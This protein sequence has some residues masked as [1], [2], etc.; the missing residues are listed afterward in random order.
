MQGLRFGRNL[1][2][3]SPETSSPFLPA[4]MQR[5][6]ADVN[7]RNSLR[8]FS[9][10]SQSELQLATLSSMLQKCGGLA[11][12]SLIAEAKSTR[13]RADEVLRKASAQRIRQRKQPLSERGKSGGAS[14]S[15]VGRLV[16]AGGPCA[17]EPGRWATR[18]CARKASKGK[19]HKRRVRSA[20]CATCGGAGR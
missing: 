13:A 2:L 12:A 1:L 16:G 6:W 8:T 17:D 18:K 4:S 7:L 15:G 20:C 3:A 11:S 14:R 10:S 19:C 5:A 9:S